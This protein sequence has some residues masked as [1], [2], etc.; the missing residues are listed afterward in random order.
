MI[1]NAMQ[2]SAF[3]AAEKIINAALEYDPASQRQIAALEGKLLLVESTLP[4]LSVAI[5]ATTNGIMLH[6]NWQDSA[7]TTV[8]GSLIAMLSLAVSSDQHIS[9]AGT[10]I[11]VTGDLEFLRQI[12]ELMR[13]LDVDWE[14]AL[15]TIIGDIPAH[16]LAKQLRS[17]SKAAADASRRAKSAAAEIAQEELRATPS[18]SEYQDF[19]QRVRH[20][21]TEVER[22]AAKLNKSRQLIEQLLAAKSATDTDKPDNS[23]PETNL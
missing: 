3:E 2:A 9:F 15:A 8:S 17:S 16:L 19:T 20:L 22:A 13:N 12:N 14:G 4:P 11:S 10:G 1:F 6:S 23:A 7:D 21:S 18:A 5:E